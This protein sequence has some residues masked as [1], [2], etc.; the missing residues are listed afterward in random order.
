M[1]LHD[2]PFSELEPR[3]LNAEQIADPMLVI[4]EFFNVGHLPQIR[5]MLWEL[6]KTT[7][8]GNYCTVLTRKERANLLYFFEQLEKLVEANHLLHKNSS[9]S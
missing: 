5:E 9:R 8:T 3:K 1:P 2:Y 7:V 4:N 6:L